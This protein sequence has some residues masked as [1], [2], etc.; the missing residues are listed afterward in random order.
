MPA[1]KAWVEC[2]VVVESN[3]DIVSEVLPLVRLL[4]QWT[5]VLS[6]KKEVTTALVRLCIRRLRKYVGDMD[7]KTS[8]LMRGSQADRVLAS[9][10][11]HFYSEAKFY[12]CHYFG[13]ALHD[14]ALLRV[15]ELLDPRTVHR[16]SSKCTSR[17]ICWTSI[18]C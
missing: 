1:R 7:S 16:R 5:Q 10:L 15:A 9:K 6:S 18:S 14:C 2:L 3:V 11:S 4:A 8:V 17:T 12:V 13:D